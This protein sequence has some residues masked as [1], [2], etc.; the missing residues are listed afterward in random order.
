ML[1]CFLYQ[2]R[3]QNIMSTQPR[4]DRKPHCDSGK[5]RSANTCNLCWIILAK[6]FPPGS[7]K[8]IPRQLSHEDKSPF[9]GIGTTKA[10]FHSWGT[11]PSHHT[12]CNSSTRWS[13]R[14]APQHL[15]ISGS[16][17]AALPPLILPSAIRISYSDCGSHHQDNPP[18]CIYHI[19]WKRAPEVE[20]MME[21]LSPAK[22]RLLR[23]WTQIT[24]SFLIGL[25][26]TGIKPTLSLWIFFK[27]LQAQPVKP[28]D[29][30]PA[31]TDLAFFMQQPV[32]CSLHCTCNKPT[33]HNI[34]LTVTIGT[35]TQSFT[36]QCI[37][38]LNQF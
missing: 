25:D 33:L 8:L 17:P 10:S 11:W 7:C 13:S 36:K 6:I 21:M 34:P 20:N 23:I 31:S 14:P 15:I 29:N 12:H 9:F 24:I 37:A 32:I 18:H 16:T 5:T 28:F 3:P 38:L 4:P 30:I 22:K 26:R 2:R 1:N 35:R 19:I 27:L